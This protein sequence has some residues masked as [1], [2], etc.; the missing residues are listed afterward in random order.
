MWRKGAFELKGGLGMRRYM[1]VRHKRNRDG[2][3]QYLSRI[4]RALTKSDRWDLIVMDSKI[5]PTPFILGIGKATHYFTEECYNSH[6]AIIDTI[7]SKVNYLELVT[8][9]SCDIKR[10]W[11]EDAEQLIIELKEGC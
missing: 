3:F 6:R 1:R 4:R 2:M 9:Q 5:T 10:I 7:I 8:V 11:F